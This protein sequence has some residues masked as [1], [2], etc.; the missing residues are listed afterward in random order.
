MLRT[1]ESRLGSASQCICSNSAVIRGCQ[2]VF[3]RWRRL[4]VENMNPFVKEMEYA[5]RGPI[6]IRAAEIEHEL[7]KG[8]KKPFRDV[9]RAN[10]GDCHATGQKPITFLRQV[11]ALCA[12]PAGLMNAAVM[13]DDAKQRA[14]RILAS[15]G[16]QSVGAYSDSAGVRVIREDI[17]KYIAERDAFPCDPDNIYLS[18]GASDSIKSVLK[19]LMTGKSGDDRAGIMIPIPQYP[20]YTAT[21][22]EYNAYPVGYFLDEDDTWALSIGELKRAI[23]AAQKHC[24]PRAIVVINPGNPTDPQNAWIKPVEP[25]L[26]S[27]VQTHRMLD[28]AC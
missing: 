20:L 1:V 4:S 27:Y 6:V 19:L 22:A 26:V 3:R 8:V 15:C 28:K 25:G 2:K 23:T 9:I 17:A 12:H 24:E 5:V 7:A 11:A 21:I 10:I 18:T 16:G 13:P 14:K